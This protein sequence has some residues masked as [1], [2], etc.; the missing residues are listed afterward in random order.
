M[1]KCMWCGSET[2]NNVLCKFC[3]IK[4]KKEAQVETEQEFERQLKLS[5]KKQS[6]IFQHAYWEV[7]HNT[8]GCDITYDQFMQEVKDLFIK[9][10][11]HKLVGC[12][13]YEIKTGEK[14]IVNEIEYNDLH[15]WVYGN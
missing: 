9:I 1:A 15:N 2:S 14:K 8:W 5:K 6:Q 10:Y 12:K 11:K 3:V 4:L 13:L 7:E